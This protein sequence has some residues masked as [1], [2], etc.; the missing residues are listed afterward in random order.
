VS[1]RETNGKLGTGYS[2]REIFVPTTI[3]LFRLTEGLRGSDLKP[4]LAMRSRRSTND[5]I[6]RRETPGQKTP[7]NYSLWIQRTRWEVVE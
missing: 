6:R 4:V 5:E 3:F 2:I 7:A 1:A